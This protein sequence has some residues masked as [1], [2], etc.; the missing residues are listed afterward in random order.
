MAKEVARIHNDQAHIIDAYLNGHFQ[1]LSDSTP[2]EASVLSYTITV[3][4]YGYKM[5]TVS[6]TECKFFHD[7][8][9]V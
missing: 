6:A 3:S 2:Y 5:Y 8:L 7:A 1:C 4:T 9:C